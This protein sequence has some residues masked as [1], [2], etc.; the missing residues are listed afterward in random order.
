M[1]IDDASHR[2]GCARAAANAFERS[3]RIYYRYPTSLYYMDTPTFLYNGG[4]HTSG[5]IR[6]MDISDGCSMHS[7]YT[8][9]THPSLYTTQCMHAYGEAHTEGGC[10]YTNIDDA[11]QD[12]GK[13]VTERG[14]G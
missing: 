13:G 12:T 3:C 9:Y 5:C 4:A 11:S 7:R 1:N 14:G 8:P 6:G 2:D 10:A